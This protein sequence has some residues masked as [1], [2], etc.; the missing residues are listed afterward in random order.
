MNGQRLA[1]L[2]AGLAGM[3]VGVDQPGRQHQAARVDHFGII[4]LGVV[5]KARAD[6][7][8]AAIL[9]QQ[10]ALDVQAR[11]RIEQPGVAEGD[12]ART[13]DVILMPDPG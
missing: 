5:E 12:A 2:R 9:H 11:G 8:D 13:H 6:V 3:D 4:G 7:R 1:M 10:P